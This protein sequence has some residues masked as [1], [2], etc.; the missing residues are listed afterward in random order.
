MYV[1]CLCCTVWKNENEIC[2][3]HT[4][5]YKHAK[6]MYGDDDDDDDYVTVFVLNCFTIKSRSGK[7]R[8]E[9]NVF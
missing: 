4:E 1:L 2:T 3:C 7:P 5:K 6:H 9:E 8:V